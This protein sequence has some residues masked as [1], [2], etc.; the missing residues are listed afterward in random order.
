M[1]ALQ[2]L[3]KEGDSEFEQGDYAGARMSFEKAW[4]SAQHVSDKA[5]VRYDVLKRLAAASAASGE[6]NTAAGYLEQAVNWRRSVVGPNDPRIATDLAM[7]VNL[8][9]NTRDFNQALSSAQQIEEMH[10]AVDTWESLSVADDLVRIAQVYLAQKKPNDGLRSL[11]TAWA[12]RTKL[13]GSLDPSLLPVLDRL[14]EATQAITGA[15][16]SESA[17][18]QALTIRE[19]IYGKDSAELM[20]TLDGF[21]NTCLKGGEFVAAEGLYERLLSLWEKLAGKDDPMVA[22]TLDKIVVLY[23]TWNRIPEARAALARSVTIREHFL[24]VGLSHQAADAIAENR[25]DEAKVVYTRALGVLESSSPGN[26]ELSAQ[27]RK[28]LLD[29]DVR[30]N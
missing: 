29:L 14:N 9:L 24:A 2:Q 20:S 17:Y 13:V 22:V 15:G 6:F 8:Y 26:R 19:S 12:I 3:L 10:A 25:R 16:G 21:A 28:A 27:I 23:K 1:A 7:L 4:E 18:R 30:P 11:S 5:V